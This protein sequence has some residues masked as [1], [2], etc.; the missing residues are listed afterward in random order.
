MSCHLP[1]F[2]R[3]EGE[4]LG[5]VSGSPFPKHTVGPM[6]GGSH[7][8][9]SWRQLR[10][11]SKQERRNPG[12][13][14][15]QR[16]GAGCA[17]CCWP[18][19]RST[20]K[21][22]WQWQ[23]LPRKLFLGACSSKA[24]SQKEGR[25]KARKPEASLPRATHGSWTLCSAVPISSLVTTVT[26]PRDNCISRG[27]PMFKI[28][29]HSGAHSITEPGS[30][31]STAPSLSGGGG[32][33]GGGLR[34]PLLPWVSRPRLTGKQGNQGIFLH[35]SNSF[36]VNRTQSLPPN[37]TCGLQAARSRPQGPL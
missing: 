26:S 35:I 31:E 18:P 11:L 16:V 34:P 21:A 32:P 33:M 37:S 1:S 27:L 25:D 3:K 14:S 8:L 15:G 7:H 12:S 19:Q 9:H 17:P 4:S 24:E 28:G 20:R 23:P 2:P 30:R 22:A 29:L 10:M 36:Q 5:Q 6:Q 13:G